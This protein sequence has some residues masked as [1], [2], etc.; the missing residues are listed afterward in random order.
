[1]LLLQFVK[2]LIFVPKLFHVVFQ[3]IFLQLLLFTYQRSS[4]FTF[5]AAFRS[6]GVHGRFLV[7]AKSVSHFHLKSSGSPTSSSHLSRTESL[8]RHVAPPLVCLADTKC[9]SWRRG[10]TTGVI[11]SGGRGAEEWWTVKCA[12]ECIIKG[13]TQDLTLSF[14]QHK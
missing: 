5:I 10:G 7:C 6:A 13:E 8:R 2:I 1:M 12:A 4:L 11:Y 14:T 3:V 9:A